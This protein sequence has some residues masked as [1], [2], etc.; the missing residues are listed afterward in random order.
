MKRLLFLPLLLLAGCSSGFSVDSYP[1]EPDTAVDC[2]ALFADGPVKV[3]GQESVFVKDENASAWGDPAII[4]RC[5]VEKPAGLN[6]ASACYP[7]GDVGWF[8]DTTADGFLFTTIGRKFYVSV[9]VPKDYDPAA[10]ALADLAEAVDKHD[11]LIKAC[12]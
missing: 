1:T 7:V 3:A 10:D 12:V 8:A 4:L 5:G 6:A 11:P 9:E 2:Q